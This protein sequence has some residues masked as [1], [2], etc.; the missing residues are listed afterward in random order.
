MNDRLGD[1]YQTLGRTE[2]AKKAWTEALA[3]T[4]KGEPFEQFLQMK[5]ESLPDA[6]EAVPAGAPAAAASLRS[7]TASPRS[8]PCAN[9]GARPPLCLQAAGRKM[10]KEQQLSGKG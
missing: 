9:A 1:V 6:D 2:D 10:R 8:R 4:Q 7:P 5:L 3:A